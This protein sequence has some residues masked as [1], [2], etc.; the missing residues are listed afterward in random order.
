MQSAARINRDNSRDEESEFD[1]G[2]SGDKIADMEKRLQSM[3]DGEDKDT[4][5]LMLTLAHCRLQHWDQARRYASMLLA[6]DPNQATARAI[7][8]SLKSKK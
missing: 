2:E 5:L 6:R 8:E 4:L 7:M 1:A 3:N